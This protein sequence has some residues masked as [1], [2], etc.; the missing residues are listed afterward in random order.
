MGFQ[1]RFSS[2]NL[3]NV[4]VQEIIADNIAQI[5]KCNR[6]KFIVNKNQRQNEKDFN[7]FASQQREAKIKMTRKN[8]RKMS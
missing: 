3:F 6:V 2:V 4:K 8:Y 7:L 5:I 1:L